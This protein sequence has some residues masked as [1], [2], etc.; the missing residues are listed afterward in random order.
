QIED[1]AAFIHV[2]M[3]E[4]QAEALLARG[5]KRR[6]VTALISTGG[7]DFDHVGAEIPQDTADKGPE[8]CCYVQDAHAF[9]RSRG[10]PIVGRCHMCSRYDTHE[11]QRLSTHC[12]DHSVSRLSGPVANHVLC[13]DEMISGRL[14]SHLMMRAFPNVYVHG[15]NSQWHD[16]IR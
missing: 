10:T 7:L 16:C 14:R 12:I 11:G 9:Q 4:G 1:D 6:E 13:P 2:G 3:D 15:Q 5:E 8:R